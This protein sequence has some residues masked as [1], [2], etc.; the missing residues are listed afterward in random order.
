MVIGAKMLGSI[1]VPSAL[2]LSAALSI[3]NASHIH[4]SI[5]DGLSSNISTR[6]VLDPEAQV[7]LS[8]VQLIE[9]ARRYAQEQGK[10]LTLASPAQGS[11]LDVLQ[12]GGFLDEISPETAKFWLHQ[13]TV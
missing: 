7:D 2:T 9:A 13:E 5:L 3:Q 12:R 11:L 6:L 4:Q 10:T 8:F 1:D